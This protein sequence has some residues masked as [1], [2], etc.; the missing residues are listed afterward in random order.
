MV[1]ADRTDRHAPGRPDRGR[2]GAGKKIDVI[3][4][5]IWNEMTAE[6]LSWVD[7]A[8]APPF[9]GVWDLIHIAARRAAEG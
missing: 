1:I 3:A 8:Y 5:A 9:G 2:P 6:D 7:L 4:T